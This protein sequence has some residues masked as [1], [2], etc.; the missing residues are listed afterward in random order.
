M[1]AG[2]AGERLLGGHASQMEVEDLDGRSHAGGGGHASPARHLGAR[3]DSGTV[4]MKMGLALM[5]LFYAAGGPRASA[6]A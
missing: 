4:D 1:S 5:G 3:G 2:P 6:D